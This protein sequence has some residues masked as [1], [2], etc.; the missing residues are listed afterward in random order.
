MKP[1]SRRRK[2]WSTSST[3]RRW[4]CTAGSTTSGRL[5]VGDVD[6]AT[7][8]LV[9]PDGR[10]ILA[11]GDA[12]TI[13][14]IKLTLSGPEWVTTPRRRSG[15]VHQVPARPRHN[16][17]NARIALAVRAPNG[18]WSG[19][20]QGPNLP[21]YGVFGSS[22]DGGIGPAIYYLD[23]DKRKRW[24]NLYGTAEEIVPGTGTSLD[25]IRFVEGQRALA[26]RL[27]VDGVP[28]AFRYDLDT[29]SSSSSPSTVARSRSS[30]CGA[31][32]SSA[33]STSSSRSS[34]HASFASIAGSRPARAAP[35]SG[36]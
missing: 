30:G 32:R 14:D 27:Q 29:K 12:Q 16:A 7:G 19:G 1:R 11:D 36:R 15:R 6:R 31:R 18:Q 4:R 2:T 26:Y 8:N 5:W 21:R 20:L 23:D 24:R 34:T 3:A 33:T 28:Q 10:Q 25:A 17:A 9:Q 22:T 35:C 13:S